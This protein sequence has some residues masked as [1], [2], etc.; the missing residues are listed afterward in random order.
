[1]IDNAPAS[2]AR[3]ARVRE[4]ANNRP[5][6]WLNFLLADVQGGLGRSSRFISLRAGTGRRARPG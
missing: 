3:P 6:D 1:M 2:G 5:L 4:R